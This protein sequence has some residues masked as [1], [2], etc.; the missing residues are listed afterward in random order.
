MHSYSAMYPEIPWGSKNFYIHHERRHE[1]EEELGNNP[2]IISLNITG[3]DA[4]MSTC[5]WPLKP[6]YVH[7]QHRA[8]N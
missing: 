1:L 4:N 6:T 8:S 2:S 3:S 5:Q 7:H